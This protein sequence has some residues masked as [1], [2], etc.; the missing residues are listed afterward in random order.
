MV[1]NHD[2]LKRKSPPIQHVPPNARVCFPP[3]MDNIYPRT[4]QGMQLPGSA[5]VTL[6]LVSKD[7]MEDCSDLE[8]S[9]SNLGA[10][11][12]TLVIKI[13]PLANVFPPAPGSHI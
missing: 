11:L 12:E 5:Y 7:G 4:S 1:D 6:K 9:V 10:E 2:R 3:K 13:N 8:E